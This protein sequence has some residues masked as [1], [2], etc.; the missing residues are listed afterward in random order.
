M[1]IVPGFTP[2]IREPDGRLTELPDA[3]ILASPI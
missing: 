1:T 2:P 3:D